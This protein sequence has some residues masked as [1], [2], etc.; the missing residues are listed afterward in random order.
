MNITVHT[1]TH[2]PWCDMAEEWL[3]NNEFKFDVILHDDDD[4]R[5]EF[6]ESCGS[7]V[8]SVPQIFVNGE[9]LGGYQDLVKSG[10]EYTNKVK[11]D[12]DF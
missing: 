7:D 8:H 4:E 5:Q 12:S 2:C 3:I 6:Y 1:K 11:F 9:R 10:L